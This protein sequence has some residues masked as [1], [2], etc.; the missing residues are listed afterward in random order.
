[1]DEYKASAALRPSN[2]SHLDVVAAIGTVKRA[3]TEKYLRSR[4]VADNHNFS[5]TVYS[6]RRLPLPSLKRKHTLEIK[7]MKCGR[8]RLNASSVKF[9]RSRGKISDCIKV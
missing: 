6:L 8:S 2:L 1:M 4:R 9:S 5:T 3:T 7:L